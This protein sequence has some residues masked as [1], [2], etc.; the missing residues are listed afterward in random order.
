VS[1]LHV[2]L[3]ETY[4]CDGYERIVTYY[5]NRYACVFMLTI[6]TV[7]FYVTI[8]KL[9]FLCK[10]V[11]KHNVVATCYALWSSLW[12]QYSCKLMHISTCLHMSWHNCQ[13]TVHELRQRHEDES[14]DPKQV[15][16]C[17]DL[18][19]YCC[20]MV[21]TKHNGIFLFVLV[22]NI[23]FLKTV[24]FQMVKEFCLP[25]MINIAKQLW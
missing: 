2:I 10:T 8:L 16:V 24:L 17:T 14:T 4:L 3:Q 19:K 25:M 13:H 9:E 6:T 15:L 21:A 1:N 18:Q 23:F 22:F 7:F 12:Q 11:L 20:V 5:L